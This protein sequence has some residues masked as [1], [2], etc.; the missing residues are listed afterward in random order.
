MWAVPTRSKA[1]DADVIRGIWTSSVDPMIDKESREAGVFT[2]AK[3][4]INACIPWERI[5]SF[6]PV[7]RFGQPYRSE[8]LAKWSD[9]FC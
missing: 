7:N 2:N 8:I 4:V 9:L 3:M 1:E 6:P 5:D